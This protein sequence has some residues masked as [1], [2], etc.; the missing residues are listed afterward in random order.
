MLAECCLHSEEWTVAKVWIVKSHFAERLCGSCPY[1]FVC[2][3]GFALGEI[4]VFQVI[5]FSS[6]SS[7]ISS[8]GLGG[9]VVAIVQPI[10][11][12]MP[13]MA[14]NAMKTGTAMIQN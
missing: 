7:V 5:F 12:P 8:I 10:H 14:T 1:L 3:C 4:I 9:G 13:I 2:G 11:A 6:V